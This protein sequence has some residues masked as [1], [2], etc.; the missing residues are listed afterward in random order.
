MGP[1]LHTDTLMRRQESEALPPL[2]LLFQEESSASSPQPGE[3]E[4]LERLELRATELDAMRH[5]PESAADESVKRRFLLLDLQGAGLFDASNGLRKDQ[6]LRQWGF[7]HL[8]GYRDAALQ[9][10]RYLHSAERSRSL[11]PADTSGVVGAP[12][13]VDWFRAGAPA[14][15]GRTP[16]EWLAFC[17]ATVRPSEIV[18]G[19]E[20]E[21]LTHVSR[22]WYRIYWR[23]D[24]GIHA[25]LVFSE[26]R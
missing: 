15:E 20:G 9:L 13:S 14:F 18:E 19:G 10:R 23:R 17:E 5:A 6:W 26:P 12:V 8:A 22:R 11:P 24:D 7:V 16:L 25:A 4:I 3:R 21:V 2:P 1:E